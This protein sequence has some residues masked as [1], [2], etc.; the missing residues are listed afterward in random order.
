M[1]CADQ[2]PTKTEP[3]FS[4][5]SRSLAAST[6]RCSGASRFVIVARFLNRSGHNHHAVALE[7]LARHGIVAAAQLCFGDHCAAPDLRAS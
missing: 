5:H 2:R 6:V 1:G 4:T 3:A 7:R